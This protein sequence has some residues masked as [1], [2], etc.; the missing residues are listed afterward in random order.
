NDPI[1]GETGGATGGET[2]GAT[3]GESGG[4][5]GGE[6]GG[7]TG[8]E[9]GGATGGETGG[10]TGGETGGSTGGDG[11]QYPPYVPPYNGEPYLSKND[12]TSPNYDSRHGGNHDSGANAE[13]ISSEA[14]F[15]EE[16]DGAVHTDTAAYGA[17]VLTMLASAAVI[18]AAR[19]RRQ[20]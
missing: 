8:G 18:F 7:A 14:G 1:S 10:A 16:S 12:P 3:G 11:S 5:T 19:K 13:D 9:T 15:D 4:A 2:G 17:I 6:T 20:K